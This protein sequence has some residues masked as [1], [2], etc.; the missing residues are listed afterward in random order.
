MI[1]NVTG[2]SR[3]ATPATVDE[4]VI[5]AVYVPL[6]RKS[7]KPTTVIVAGAVVESI[8]MVSQPNAS[9]PY[10]TLAERPLSVPPPAFVM[11]T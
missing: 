3:G 2:R 7:A 1:V 6:S 4:I 10:A 5:V 9:A 11:A 8:A